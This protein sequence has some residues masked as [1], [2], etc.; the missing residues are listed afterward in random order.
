MFAHI[1]EKH[2]KF[3]MLLRI[4]PGINTVQKEQNVI[5]GW[6]WC[7]PDPIGFI[8]HYALDKCSDPFFFVIKSWSHNFCE[9]I[10]NLFVTSLNIGVVESGS[11]N[12]SHKASR[13]RFDNSSYRF[14]GLFVIE[15]TSKLVHLK[16]LIVEHWNRWQGGRFALT[17]FTN[18]NCCPRHK[19]YLLNITL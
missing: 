9:L 1:V 4:W 14:V 7:F 15:T 17:A 6:D 16:M 10:E 2:K 5:H 19:I 13:A 3:W 18:C 12:Q 8:R 11:V